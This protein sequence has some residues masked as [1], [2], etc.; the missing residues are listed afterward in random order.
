MLDESRLKQLYDENYQLL[1]SIGRL[2]LGA[3]EKQIASVE[4]AIQETFLLL[5]EK[6]RKL[7][8]HP[9]LPGWLVETLRRKLLG[10][11]AKSKRR[12]WHH[13]YSLDA[14]EADLVALSDKTFPMPETATLDLSRQEALET[15]LGKADAALFAQYFI[16]NLTAKELSDSLG[17]SADCIRMRAVRLRKKVLANQTLFLGIVALLYVR[18]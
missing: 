6:R 3:E 13:A 12:A 14:V 4:D 10:A 8:S 15:L 5:W 1:Y 7:H 18:F 11:L 16:E 17:V 2:F 9:N